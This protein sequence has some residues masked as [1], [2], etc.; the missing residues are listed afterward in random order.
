MCVLTYSYI[1][2]CVPTYSAAAA[3]KNS[4]CIFYEKSTPPEKK[5][6]CIPTHTR[7]YVLIYKGILTCVY[8]RVR[9][10]VCT[11]VLIYKSIPTCAYLHVRTYVLINKSIPTCAYLHVR[12]YVLINKCAYLRT[13]V[14]L[15]SL[16]IL[17][18]ILSEF[19][20]IFYKLTILIFF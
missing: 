19:L 9:T 2:V 3:S 6:F 5:S 13:Y 1:N 10:Y 16:H 15:Y 12:T 17:W 18:L 8:L 20:Q 14:S 11:Y 7:T 4:F